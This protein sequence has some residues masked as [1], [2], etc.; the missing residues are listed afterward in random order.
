MKQR[1]PNRGG[2]VKLGIYN[3]KKK[4]LEI[5]SVGWKYTRDN[6]T[7]KAR[8][9][10]FCSTASR[11]SSVRDFEENFAEYYR[12]KAPHPPPPL[13]HPR[14]LVWTT[15]GDLYRPTEMVTQTPFRWTMRGERGEKAMVS[16]CIYL[17]PLIF[18][19]CNKILARPK[20]SLITIWGW[21]GG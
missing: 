3:K 4:K 20:R 9:S 16:L 14:V 8:A 21:G 18:F 17:F 19:S 2:G 15:L 13:H 7:N 6:K 1:Q 5:N 12:L 11:H 10:R